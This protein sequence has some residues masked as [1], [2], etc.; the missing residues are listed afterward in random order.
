MAYVVAAVVVLAVLV[1]LDLL[2]TFAVLRRLRIHEARL[3]A[4]G[5][6]RDELIGRRLPR[7]G[8]SGATRLVAFFSA[9]CAP[10]VEQAAEFAR[11]AD[12]ERVAI[13]VL[14]SA[15]ESERQRLLTALGDAPTVITEPDGD[16]LAAELG[17]RSFP[18]LL[19]VD[20]SGTI[21]AAR[22][23]LAALAAGVA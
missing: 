2:L 9:G 12:A 14:G 20:E 19:L 22:H 17:V 5:T 6:V 4:P 7:F 13:L 1:V 10:C 18:Q 23:S 8:A 3:S 11:H 21:V 15:S 16:A